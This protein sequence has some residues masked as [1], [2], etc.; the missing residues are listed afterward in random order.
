MHVVQFANGV[1]LGIICWLNVM[2]YWKN[3]H[4][5]SY[6]IPKIMGCVVQCAIFISNGRLT[7]LLRLKFFCVLRANNFTTILKKAAKLLRYAIISELFSSS[8]VITCKIVY[9]C[10]S[11]SPFYVHVC[12]C[13]DS[14]VW[15]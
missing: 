4:M 2:L 13:I 10:L 7:A 11:R 12:F 3:Q 6:C 15:C 1:V 5:H 9:F 8:C 14:L